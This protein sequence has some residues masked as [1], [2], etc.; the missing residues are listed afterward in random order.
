VTRERCVMM[1]RTIR[2]AEADDAHAVQAIYAPFVS[3]SATSFET[4][5]PDVGEIGR[6]IEAQRE[7]YPWLV[8]E[9]D[10]SVVGYAYASAHR[11][12]QAYQWSVDVSVYVDE[13]FQ[14][15]GIGRA[16]YLALFDLL[17]R[18]RFVNAY[19][20][21]TLPNPASVGL[22]RSLGFEPIGV[23]RQ[24]GFKFDRWHDVIWLHLRL[25]E[26]AAIPADPLPIA[27]LW[28]DPPVV[29]LLRDHALHA[30]VR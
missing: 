20:G 11:T 10:G 28:A 22:H 5:V 2:S 1:D 6:R 15:R 30:S 23:Y 27:E 12:R 19:A 25:R 7:R 9:V 8:F 18:Q 29:A 24:V 21:I 16:L 26:D 14:R 4:V 3:D 13:R 17:R